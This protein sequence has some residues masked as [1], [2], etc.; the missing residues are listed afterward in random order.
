MH[1]DFDLPRS[2]T[3]QKTRSC[4]ADCYVPQA[5]AP[6]QKLRGNDASSGSDSGC[7]SCDAIEE[8]LKK[9][10]SEGAQL[11]QEL[12]VGLHKLVSTKH[13]LLVK[14]LTSWIFTQELNPLVK[15]GAYKKKGDWNLAALKADIAACS[16]GDDEGQCQAATCGK[17]CC[18][19]F[20]SYL[21]LP[22]FLFYVC[23]HVTW[24][25]CSLYLFHLII[26]CIHGF[27][28]P[29]TKLSGVLLFRVSQ[30]THVLMPLHFHQGL[31]F[32]SKP[33]QH[34]TARSFQHQG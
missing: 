10:E 28:S 5:K 18:P 2:C 21:R 23:T 3:K 17:R 20:H 13:M 22:C 4:L 32:K 24:K 15:E 1:L 25:R 34:L 6:T 14:F 8:E 31:S 27:E 7:A 11:F 29:L 9:A 16:G 26:L 19:D 30:H 12:K 33:V